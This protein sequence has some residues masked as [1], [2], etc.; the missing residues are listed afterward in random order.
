[1]KD[2]RD[3]FIESAG[4]M[5][6][7]DIKQ[8]SRLIQWYERC[9]EQLKDRKYE[10]SLNAA[11]LAD[12]CES[13][14]G[15]SATNAPSILCH[16]HAGWACSPMQKPEN[17]SYVH[18]FYRL[19]TKDSLTPEQKQNTETWEVFISKLKLEESP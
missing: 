14:F 16:P 1:M 9:E 10:A 6:I 17:E 13:I 5:A 12:I 8:F 11:M 2:Y 18:A 19:I 4:S 3:W 15:G 7:E